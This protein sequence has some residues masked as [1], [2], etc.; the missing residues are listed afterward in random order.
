MT[1]ARGVAVAGVLG[2]EANFHST[3][4]RKG[5]VRATTTIQGVAGRGIMASVM[6]VVV[7]IKTGLLRWGM[8]VGSVEAK[9]AGS[10]HRTTG[11]STS[12]DMLFSHDKNDLAPDAQS[13]L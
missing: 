2:V 4:K 1:A 11:Q 13:A 5:E 10:F 8:M 7:E 12:R 3:I 6:A 9:A